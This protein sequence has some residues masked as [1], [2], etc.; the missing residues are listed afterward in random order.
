MFPDILCN[1]RFWA[2]L[3]GPLLTWKRPKSIRFCNILQAIRVESCRMMMDDVWW[4]WCVQTVR[5][6]GVGWGKVGFWILLGHCRL[7]CQGAMQLQKFA[8]LFHHMGQRQTIVLTIGQ[9][10]TPTIG[11]QRSILRRSIMINLCIHIAHWFTM[12]QRIPLRKSDSTMHQLTL[13]ESDDRSLVS[14]LRR[15]FG[16]KCHHCKRIREP[17]DMVL[18]DV[19]HNIEPTPIVYRYIYA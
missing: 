1:N 3:I 13:P 15:P 14:C 8:Q 16:I 2:H 18:G 4:L 10:I 6:W 9:W 19:G 5:V 7:R 11:W 12:C 17:P